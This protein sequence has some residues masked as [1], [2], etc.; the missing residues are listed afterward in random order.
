M[1]VF[2]RT[3]SR[4]MKSDPIVALAFL[5]IAE[6]FGNYITCNVRV[7]AAQSFRFGIY[8]PKF[9]TDCAAF[10]LRPLS[11]FPVNL[12]RHQNAFPLSLIHF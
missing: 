11:N 9:A 8:Q 7:A 12:Y 10:A 6:G 5:A 3:F 2:L 4:L 1:D